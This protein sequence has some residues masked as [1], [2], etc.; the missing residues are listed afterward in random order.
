M[1]ARILRDR[2]AR[3]NYETLSRD[4]PMSAA[5]IGAVAAEP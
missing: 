1:Q 2:A 3:M 4:V 5:L